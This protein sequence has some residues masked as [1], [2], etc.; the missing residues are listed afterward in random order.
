M[1]AANV[2]CCQ[3]GPVL[4]RLQWQLVAQTTVNTWDTLDASSTHHVY[5]HCFPLH[6][7]RLDR[8]LYIPHMMEELQNIT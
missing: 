2:T 7:C 1:N 8:P 6:G 5:I 4:G 3:Y